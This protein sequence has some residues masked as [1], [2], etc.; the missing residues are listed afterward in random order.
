MHPPVANAEAERQEAAVR[1][2]P[3]PRAC[4]SPEDGEDQLLDALWGMAPQSS[5]ADG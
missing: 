4:A 1:P 3:E 2:G 5:L